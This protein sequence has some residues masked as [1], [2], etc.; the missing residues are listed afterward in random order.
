MAALHDP[1]PSSTTSTAATVGPE[2]AIEVVV[3]WGEDHA[4]ADVLHV[5][6][7][8]EGCDFAVGDAVRPDGSSATD[9][10][11]DRAQLGHARMPVIVQGE[12]GPLLVVPKGASLRTVSERG[13]TRTAAQLVVDGALCG[14]GDASFPFALPLER[15]T[16]AWLGYRGFTFFVRP[17]LREAPLGL[18]RAPAWRDQRFTAAS[19]AAHLFVLGLFYYAAPQSSALA[20]DAT[21]LKQAYLDYLVTPKEVE[22]EPLPEWG[23]DG[24]G[25]PSDSAHALSGEPGTNGEPK[26]TATR[27][28]K[29][30]QASK[31]SDAE[32]TREALR[33]LASQLTMFGTIRA[34]AAPGEGAYNAVSASGYDAHSALAS[35]LATHDG[36]SFGEG[37]GPIGTGRGGG[38]TAAGTIAGGHLKT[39]GGIGPGTGGPGGA[40]GYGGRAGRLGDRTA[41][42]PAQ[43]ASAVQVAGGLSKEAIRRTIH[44][45]LSQVRFCYE[46]SL[47]A[48][49][50]LQGRVA[51]RFIIGP[52][53]AVQAAAIA[54]DDVGD[55]RVAACIA[56]AVGRWLFP[57]P[58]GS[59]IVS[60]TYPFVLQQVAP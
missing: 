20:A 38:G 11:I 13:A 33:E 54:S 10:L 31:A 39:I 58:E 46:E 45:N 23:D 30:M 2:P 18:E 48:K 40:G 9:Y 43:P 44:R 35:L 25:T 5:G 3:L 24:G 14:S 1:V 47:Q 57:A 36:P 59:G 53:G 28:K 52:S 21:A 42:V 49:P 8:S 50:D 12:R 22:L 6:Y 4:G 16:S 17:T 51:V 26:A 15:G 60:V 19:V 32:P 41:R 29:T 55:A 37:L 34:A 27:S 56:G 7:V